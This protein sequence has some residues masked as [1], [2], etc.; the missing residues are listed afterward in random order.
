MT[1][2]ALLLFALVACGE[3]ATV[4]DGYSVSESSIAFDHEV[5]T[6]DCPQDLGDVEVTNTG[7]DLLVFTVSVDDVGGSDLIDFGDGDDQSPTSLDDVE[8]EVDP[9]ASAVFVPWFNCQQ[10]TSFTTTIRIEPEGGLEPT[11]IPVTATIQ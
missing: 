7:E 4:L 11:S 3:P 1:K 9:G 6:T 2:P 8:I 10:P 5:G